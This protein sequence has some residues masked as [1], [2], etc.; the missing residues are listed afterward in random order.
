MSQADTADDEGA[1]ARR[2]RALAD[3]SRLRLLAHITAAGPIGIRD[4]AARAGLHVNTVRSH[5]AM[6]E[7]VGLVIGEA[8]ASG[9]RGRPRRLYRDTRPVTG[10]AA[11]Q[12]AGDV[13]DAV[14]DVEHHRLLA[15]IMAAAIA[16]GATGNP[17]DLA[18][19]AEAWGR[20]LMQARSSRVG[21]SED[22]AVSELAN[23]LD[24]LG[25][26]PELQYAPTGEP[27]RLLMRP[28]PFHDLSRRY[29]QVVC[30]IHLGIMRGALQRA[31]GDMTTD[32]LVPYAEPGACIAHLATTT[33]R[34]DAGRA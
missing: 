16:Q 27:A 28:C 26:A 4:L 8:R 20:H 6:L 33:P 17:E 3:P 19:V 13:G 14:D 15:E 7:E 30:P 1:R 24:E 10:R 22:D 29:Q 32:T 34:P 31:G 23:L 12:D 25:F 9:E 18:L 5:V 21:G 2:H 11:D